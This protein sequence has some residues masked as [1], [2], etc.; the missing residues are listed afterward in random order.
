MVWSSPRNAPKG[1]SHFR[2]AGP[3]VI[4][5]VIGGLCYVTMGLI[6]L[7]YIIFQGKHSNSQFFRF[8]FLQ[9]I[10]LGIIGL[11]LQWT[12]SIFINLFGGIVGLIPGTGSGGE[13]IG[14]IALVFTWVLRAASILL[15]YGMVFAFLGKYAEIPLI[16]KLVRQQLR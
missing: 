13:I 7:L 15:L 16:S 11:L 12:V 2:P 10:L 4:E 9:A 6:G 1:P 5:R 14:T 3:E 8:H